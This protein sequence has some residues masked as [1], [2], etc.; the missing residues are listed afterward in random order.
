MAVFQ[1]SAEPYTADYLALGRQ[2]AFLLDAQKDAFSAKLLPQD[3]VFLTE[4]SDHLLLLLA[5]PS[6]NGHGK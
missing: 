4:V 5:H 1:Q 2:T 6:G 3:A